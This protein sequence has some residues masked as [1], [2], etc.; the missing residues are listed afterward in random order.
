MGAHSD[1]E[2]SDEG[3]AGHV[4]EMSVQ[5]YLYES[6]LSAQQQ[7]ELLA[8]ENNDPILQVS[9][10]IIEQVIDHIT[11]TYFV[12]NGEMIQNMLASYAQTFK[13]SNVIFL[14]CLNYTDI[15]YYTLG[16]YGGYLYVGLRIHRP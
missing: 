10:C 7:R 14:S 8:N 15:G 16:I 13:K 5:P 2:S 9:R 4:E 12:V 1:S 3:L 11:H 6:E